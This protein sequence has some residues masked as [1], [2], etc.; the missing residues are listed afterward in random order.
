MISQAPQPRA[1]RLLS[2]GFTIRNGPKDVK[3]GKA[4]MEA[5]E[6]KK[7]SHLGG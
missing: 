7:P 5:R 1:L 3:G 6:E 2:P 4:I